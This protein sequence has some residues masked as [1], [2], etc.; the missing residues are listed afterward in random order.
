MLLKIKVES[1]MTKKVV[2]HSVPKPNTTI[3]Q[4]EVM[5][6]ENEYDCTT[7]IDAII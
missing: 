1:I 7:S 6:V 4:L 2:K 3:S 5:N